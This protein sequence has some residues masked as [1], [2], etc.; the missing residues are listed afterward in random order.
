MNISKLIF[1]TAFSLT[2]IGTSF[3]PN[4]YVS[5]ELQSSSSTHKSIRPQTEVFQDVAAYGAKKS[6]TSNT[7]DIFTPKA[8]ASFPS[9]KVIFPPYAE[10]VKYFKDKAVAT[11]AFISNGSLGNTIDI[12][13]APADGFTY[14][15]FQTKLNGTDHVFLT[16][17][18]APTTS[19]R[20]SFSKPVELTPVHHGIISHLQIAAEKNRAFVVW[21]DYNS[22]TGLNS[23]F[24]SSSL[25]SGKIFRTFRGS[26]INTDAKDP[27]VTP[28]GLMAWKEECRPP[29][30][31]VF[32]TG[33]NR[34]S[35]AI[36]TET[37]VSGNQTVGNASSGD[38][39][40]CVM[41]WPIW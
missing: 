38:K 34:S 15:V 25:E 14:L 10:L 22:T 28:N 19:H 37:T 17:Y 13:A 5:A 23:I 2:L 36:T 30:V 26:G 40:Y 7:T 21:Q 4:Y 39:I 20:I 3:L 29:D 6:M 8:N 12:N 16:K 18:K 27:L 31:D 1:A 33:T 9:P 35:S 32:A 11:T 24:V 41:A